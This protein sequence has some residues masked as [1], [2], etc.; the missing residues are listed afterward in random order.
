MVFGGTA[1]IFLSGTGRSVAQS[2]E[3]SGD[4]YEPDHELSALT[5]SEIK[6]GLY[7]DDKNFYNSNSETRWTNVHKTCVD[8]PSQFEPTLANGFIFSNRI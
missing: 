7:S 4:E 5:L 2:P 6:I 3:E 1:E 8:K